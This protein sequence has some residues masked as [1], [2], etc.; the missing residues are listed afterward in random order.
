MRVDQGSKNEGLED[1]LIGA[2]S[3]HI[4][5]LAIALLSPSLLA[6][7]ENEINFDSEIRN[8]G[9]VPTLAHLIFRPDFIFIL[10]LGDDNIQ[11]VSCK[12]CLNYSFSLFLI[13]VETTESNS[14][15]DFS[16]QIEDLPIRHVYSRQLQKF[17]PIQDQRFVFHNLYGN[18]QFSTDTNHHQ[19]PTRIQMPAASFP[20]KCNV[21]MDGIRARYKDISIRLRTR[22]MEEVVFLSRTLNSTAIQGSGYGHI[23]LHHLITDMRRFDLETRTIWADEVQMFVIYCRPYVRMQTSLRVWLTPFQ[24]NV[25]IGILLVFV[26][27]TT[28][29]RDPGKIMVSSITKKF[30]NYITTWLSSSYFLLSLLLREPVRNF[31]R[32][33]VPFVAL[34]LLVTWGYEGC[35]TT[36][37]IAPAEPFRYENVGQFINSSQTVVLY[38]GY[39][40][41][42]ELVNEY[43]PVFLT[44]LKT[45]GIAEE[46]KV[47]SFRII[48]GAGH[49]FDDL[50]MRW[51]NISHM[52]YLD[53][54]TRSFV[55]VYM[56]RV[57]IVMDLGKVEGKDDTYKCQQFPFG[58]AKMSF[59]SFKFVL[60][61]RAMDLHT[62]LL[63]MPPIFFFKGTIQRKHKCHVIPIFW[64]DFLT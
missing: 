23:T 44:E 3:H 47:R 28:T 4:S 20:I 36:N 41:M 21:L 33:Y 42:P 38:S 61:R 34:V 53:C 26:V 31:S 64:L 48:R 45:F 6:R 15:D 40:N 29:N 62:F 8:G 56:E 18:P 25:W 59:T 37:I 30:T 46:K 1:V 14:F 60:A 58:D 50:I 27:I 5:N 10:V 39:L 55:P 35:I 49:L 63:E 32:A 22:F 24:T 54:R 43:N 19:L 11:K 52:G 16:L 57:Q 13:L 7:R 2:G 12:G 51:D 9:F 17:E